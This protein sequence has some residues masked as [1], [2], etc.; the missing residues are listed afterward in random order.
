MAGGAIQLTDNAREA[1]IRLLGPSSDPRVD[2]FV[3]YWSSQSC[4]EN[5]QP[6]QDIWETQETAGWKLKL[7]KL[8]HLPT[9]T[10]RE[11][12]GLH[13]FLGSDQSAHLLDFRDDILLL[14]GEPVGVDR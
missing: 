13:F 10:V 3:V 1:L 2:G 9:E 6:E 12:G 7:A 8:D 14:D 5:N 4:A 11:A